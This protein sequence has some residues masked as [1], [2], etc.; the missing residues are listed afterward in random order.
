MLALL[1]KAYI[2]RE[3]EL[4][5]GYFLYGFVMKIEELVQEKSMGTAMVYQGSYYALKNL[6]GN[7]KFR[8]ITVPYLSDT[9]DGRNPGRMLFLLWLSHY[10]KVPVW[11]A[12]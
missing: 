11:L 8:E 3:P 9:S 4:G 1:E 5:K 2:P 7:K 12:A 10:S 6:Q